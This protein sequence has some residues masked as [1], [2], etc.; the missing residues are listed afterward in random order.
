MKHKQRSPN[1][2]RA[3]WAL[4]DT[5]RACRRAFRPHPPGRCF[6]H[7][8]YWDPTGRFEDHEEALATADTSPD[9][10]T[11]PKPA[12]DEETAERL[13]RKAP[14]QARL[15][16]STAATARDGPGAWARLT[17]VQVHAAY[18]P[19]RPH[20]PHPPPRPPPL[21]PPPPPPPPQRYEL[22]EDRKDATAGAM[23]T[24]Q[25]VVGSAVGTADE[26]MAA[27]RASAKAEAQRALADAAAAAERLAT[28]G[29]ADGP[30]TPQ[31][32]RRRRPR[33]AG[34]SSLASSTAS[35]E[36]STASREGRRRRRADPL[37][38]ECE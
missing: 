27:A 36:A 13:V 10:K 20:R 22:I 4:L 24:A 37:S 9:R 30:E 21:P 38:P 23:A 32:Q 14:V 1:L 31:P 25:A 7:I 29:P 11:E 2:R 12:M 8:R 26:R 19:Q 18:A 5:G 15:D 34:D 3:L 6:Q 33:A 16:A 28:D 17:W 35:A